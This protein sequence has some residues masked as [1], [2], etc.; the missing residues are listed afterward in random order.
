MYKR[1]AYGVT[2]TTYAGTDLTSETTEIDVKE[3]DIIE[4]VNLV[5]SKVTAVGYYTVKKGDIGV[6]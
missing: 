4:V 5:S 2:K 6:A 1:Q 3:G